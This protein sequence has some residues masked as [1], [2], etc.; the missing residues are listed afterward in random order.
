MAIQF[1]DR[2][3]KEKKADDRLD[4]KLTAAGLISGAALYFIMSVWFP[5]FAGSGLILLAVIA[6]LACCARYLVRQ[7]KENTKSSK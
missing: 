7:R 6:I 4:S 5:K 3:G 2:I 1:E